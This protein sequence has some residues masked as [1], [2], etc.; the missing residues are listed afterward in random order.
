M[1]D[2]NLDLQDREDIDLRPPDM[3]KVI[4]HND[5]Y[6]P[7]DFVTL[8]LQKYFGKT[9][10]KATAITMDVHRKGKGIAGIYTYDIASTKIIQVKMNS[11]EAGYPL[12]TSIEKA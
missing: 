6:T 12:K 10:Q 4:L 2:R 11:K 7:I 3:F 1:S 9:L 8:M 5:D